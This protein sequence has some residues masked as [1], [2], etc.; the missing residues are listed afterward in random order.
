MVVIPRICVL[1]I[2]LLCQVVELLNSADP[3]THPSMFVLQVL[4]GM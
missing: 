1:D 4:T 2:L 3:A